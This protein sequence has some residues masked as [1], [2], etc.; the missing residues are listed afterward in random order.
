M[1][2][3]QSVTSIRA[4]RSFRARTEFCELEGI[5]KFSHTELEDRRRKKLYTEDTEG[6]RRKNFGVQGGDNKLGE[7]YWPRKMSQR[8]SAL[9]KRMAAATIQAITTVKRELANSSILLRS[10]VNWI[11]GITANGN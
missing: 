9:K 4:R 6:Q 10:P 3:T 11:S 1:A 7:R 5:R 2:T 8:S